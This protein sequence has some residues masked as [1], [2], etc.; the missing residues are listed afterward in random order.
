MEGKIVTVGAEGRSR[1][2]HSACPFVHMKSHV[3]GFPFRRGENLPNHA[4]GWKR[5]SKER[6]SHYWRVLLYFLNV[7]IP[8]HTLSHISISASLPHT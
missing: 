2:A 7:S 5:V 1:F 8:A 6:Q 4:S 3:Y